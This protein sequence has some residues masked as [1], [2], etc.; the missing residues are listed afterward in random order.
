MADNA[1]ALTREEIYAFVKLASRHG[2]KATEI[3]NVLQEVDQT[4]IRFGTICRCVK[5]FS[6]L[7]K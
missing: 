7:T 1:Y 5:D 4:C 2:K 6:N 3:V